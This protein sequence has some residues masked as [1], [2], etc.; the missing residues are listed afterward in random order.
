[1]KRLNVSCLVI[2]R[3][4]NNNRRPRAILTADRKSFRVGFGYNNP[5]VRV[6]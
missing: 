2:S 1:M 3:H 6:K 4:Y 5:H